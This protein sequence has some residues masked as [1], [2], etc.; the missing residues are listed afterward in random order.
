MKKLS[1]E[2][3]FGNSKNVFSS[4]TAEQQDKD[5]QNTFKN[6]VSEKY[7]VSTIDTYFNSFETYKKYVFGAAKKDDYT[8]IWQDLGFAKYPTQKSF[9]TPHH[10]K[11]KVSIYGGGYAFGSDKGNVFEYLDKYE[12]VSDILSYIA[13]LY[14]L[15]YE[16]VSNTHSKTS[17][18]KSSTNTTKTEYKPLQIDKNENKAY[19]ENICKEL[20]LP[21]DN[22]YFSLS[23]N[24]FDI[25]YTDLDKNPIIDN[26]GR[27]FTRQRY[28]VPLVDSKGKTKKYNSKKDSGYF[29]FL[30]PLAYNQ[31][32]LETSKTLYCTEGEK[33]ALYGVQ[34]LS[35]PFIGIGGIHLGTHTKKNPITSKSIVSTAEFSELTKEVIE[36]FNSYNLLFDS[37]SFDNLN[38]KKRALSFFAAVKKEFIAAQKVGIKEF[39]FS[40][41]NPNNPKKA[42]GLDDLGIYHSAKEIKEKLQDNTHHNDLFYHFRLD[43]TKTANNALKHLKNAFLASAYKKVDT[44][45]IIK[46]DSTYIGNSLLNDINSPFVTSLLSRKFTYLVAPTGLGKSYFVEHSLVPFLSQ[47]GFITLFVSPRSGLTK[48][49]AKDR[50]RFT[51]PTNTVSIERLKTEIDS[52]NIVYSNYDNLEIAYKVLT[53]FYN[54]S[55]FIVVD[56]VHKL[57]QDCS[58]NGREKVIK[59]VCDTLESNPN[60]L[61]LTATYVDINLNEPTN[62]FRIESSKKEPYKAPTLL[63]C[64]TTKYLNCT[65]ENILQ[66]IQ[67]GN[68][69]LVHYNHLDSCKA[70][71]KELESK[72]IKTRIC[73]SKEVDTDDLEFFNSIQNDTNFVWNSKVEVI[74]CTSVL[75]LGINLKTDRNTD[76][77]FVNKAKGFDFSSYLQFIARFRNYTSFTI[78]NT[79]ISY[80][81]KYFLPC[82]SLSLN[83]DFTENYLCAAEQKDLFNKQLERQKEYAK[84]RFI[85]DR[86]LKNVLYNKSKG[87]FEVNR[88]FLFTEQTEN[89]ILKGSPYFAVPTQIEFYESEKENESLIEKVFEIQLEK[90]KAQSTIY[91]LYLNDFYTLLISV[92]KQ[93]KDTKLQSKCNLRSNP[94][95]PIHLKP[96]ELSAA[97]KLLTNHFYI[98]KTVKKLSPNDLECSSI[99]SVLVDKESQTIRKTNDLSRNKKAYIIYFLLTNTDTKNRIRETIQINELQRLISVFSSYKGKGFLL[100][101]LAKEVNKNR[102][103]RNVYSTL[104]IVE[105]LEILTNFK[106]EKKVVDSKKVSFYSITEIKNFSAEMERLKE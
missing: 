62:N 37:D 106:K 103:G 46:I 55:V 50:I 31:N 70:L 11:K 7:Y 16:L 38:D 30:T 5:T 87:V 44:T 12:N 41:V 25:A 56:E 105:Y 65:L 18:V 104:Q 34:T 26:V 67:K 49:Q 36:K 76:L 32:V 15:N 35:L 83:Y 45:Q 60:N 96:F 57:V 85:L 19:F 95:E 43:A 75:E 66:S 39:T 17:K 72:N 14:N 2:K 27:D 13:N 69:V 4:L 77:Y 64:K 78:T 61:L 52:T 86:Q 28:F 94:N 21:I 53:E 9:K 97:E 91:E 8:T 99:K 89:E 22:P 101:D 6:K 40:I 59:A 73:A 84:D 102:I 80:Y 1:L 100:S 23:E 79:I 92:F 82:Q 68:R 48:Q 63:F 88:E 98:A 90:E 47:L 71:K 29:P 3:S 33:K 81:S 10:T 42:K 74:L 54:K 58:I 51:A 20:N 24:G 93:T